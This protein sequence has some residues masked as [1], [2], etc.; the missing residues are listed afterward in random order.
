MHV[1]L[2]G[3]FL[4]YGLY[5]S[6]NV[7]QATNVSKLVCKARKD[8]NAMTRMKPDLVPPWINLVNTGQTSSKLANISQDAF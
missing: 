4:T 6:Y 2:T 5:L 7:N 1:S 3:A 8:A